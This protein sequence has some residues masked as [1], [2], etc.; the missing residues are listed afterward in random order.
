M[1]R[2]FIQYDDNYHSPWSKLDYLLG[3]ITGGISTLLFNI[4][5]V[6]LT[7]YHLVQSNEKK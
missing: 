6:R 4:T 5:I 7:S 3:G 2:A 1:R